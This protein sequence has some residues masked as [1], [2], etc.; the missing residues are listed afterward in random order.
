MLSL[1]AVMVTSNR[2]LV[3]LYVDKTMVKPTNGY[4]LG[5]KNA[6]QIKSD[7]VPLILSCLEAKPVE[8]Q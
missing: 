1:L 7:I 2:A 8:E 5:L 3:V 4:K 6:L